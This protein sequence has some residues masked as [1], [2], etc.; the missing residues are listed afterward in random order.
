MSMAAPQLQQ[1]NNS[2]IAARQAEGDP[3]GKANGEIVDEKY[4]QFNIFDDPTHHTGERRPPTRPKQAATLLQ[5]TFIGF[6]GVKDGLPN[7]QPDGQPYLQFGLNNDPTVLTGEVR[8]PKRPTK[9]K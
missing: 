8:P 2:D 9:G 4:L 7:S 6:A 5:E 1:E 3:P